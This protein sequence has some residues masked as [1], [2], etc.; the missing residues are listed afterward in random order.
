MFLTPKQIK[1]FESESQPGCADFTHQYTIFVRVRQIAGVSVFRVQ[2]V[3]A[4]EIPRVF[5]ESVPENVTDEFLVH[6]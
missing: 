6:H 5:L 4:Q 3:R 2:F 1:Q